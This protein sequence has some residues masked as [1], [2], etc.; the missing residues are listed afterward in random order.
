[1]LWQKESNQPNAM[2][3]NMS[4]G[5]NLNSDFAKMMSNTSRPNRPSKKNN[6]LAAFYRKSGNAEFT[7]DKFGVALECY[8]QSLLFAENG[9]EDIALAYGN[10]SAC[11]F[12]LKKY[13]KCLVDIQLAIDANYPAKLMSKLEK[14][15]EECIRLKPEQLQLDEPRLSFHHDTRFP[16]LANAVQL[17]YNKEFGRHFV[18]N[19]DID[20]G[21][22]ILVED[23]YVMGQLRENTMKCSICFKEEVNLIPCTKCTNA[24]FCSTECPTSG[25]HHVEC[26]TEIMSES[27]FDPTVFITFRSVLVAINIFRDVDEMMRF[28]EN[29]VSK[30]GKE[31]PESISDVR[32]KYQAFL[33]LSM[34]G[35]LKNCKSKD[36]IHVV[37]KLLLQNTQLNQLFKRTNHR[38]FLLHLIGHHLCV[39]E[40]NLKPVSTFDV[41]KNYYVCILA[42]YFNHSCS[43][44]VVFTDKNNLTICKVVRPVQ[45]GEQLFIHYFQHETV[46]PFESRK[47]QLL[48]QF[49]FKCKC[50]QCNC[51]QL[52]V[53]DQQMINADPMWQL[54]K[55][56]NPFTAILGSNKAHSQNIKETCEQFLRKYGRTIWSKEICYVVGLYS[57]L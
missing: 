17:T 43:P 49:G 41:A 46:I 45:Q 12:H 10:R 52:S 2:Y 4:S 8:N 23:M 32:S 13:D 22:T 55:A 36:S 50:E 26:S 47:T 6:E 21:Q 57:G 31:I 37:N 35:N 40:R 53:I 39:F 7:E 56:E 14:R 19:C 28:V 15:R 42:S 34:D 54:L 48:K 1:M 24:L 38:R 20:V 44:N 29:C 33:Q 9:T 11:F 30:K 3:I 16:C 51:R 5:A 25:I 18:A 27:D